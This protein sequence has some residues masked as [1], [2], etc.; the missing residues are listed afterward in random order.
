MTYYFAQR[1]NNIFGHRVNKEKNNIV[2]RLPQKGSGL[3]SLLKSFFKWII[4]A[5]KSLLSA[6]KTAAQT[7]A[8]SDLA[9]EAAEALKKE[10]AT[11]GINLAQSAFRG[12]NFKENLSKQSKIAAKNIGK[13][14]SQSLENYRPTEQD[15]E[16]KKKAKKRAKTPLT[17]KTKKF[18]KDNL[19]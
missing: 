9:K 8:K 6:G 5:G 7:V 15:V 18:I 17:F 2:L 1:P 10:A 19:S 4:P 3:G 13:T 12:E 11:A 16:V 14:I